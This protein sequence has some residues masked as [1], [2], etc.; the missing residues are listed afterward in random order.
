MLAKLPIDVGKLVDL[1]HQDHHGA[2]AARR[3]HARRTRLRA[4][5]RAAAQDLTK[6]DIVEL[7]KIR[8]KIEMQDK[9]TWR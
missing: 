2:A 3:L 8:A 1:R 9:S 4:D 6:P 5:R 7:H